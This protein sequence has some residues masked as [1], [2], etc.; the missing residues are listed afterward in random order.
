MFDA[1]VDGSFDDA[2]TNVGPKHH[3]KDSRGQLSVKGQLKKADDIY[4]GALYD[5]IR[6]EPK[7]EL[8]DFDI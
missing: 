5:M 3:L 7:M 4:V 2:P 8:D 1:Y 6:T